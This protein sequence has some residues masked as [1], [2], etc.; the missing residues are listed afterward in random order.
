MQSQS[1]KVRDDDNQVAKRKKDE[2]GNKK[3]FPLLYWLFTL[4]FITC[5]MHHLDA[6]WTPITLDNAEI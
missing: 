2:S 6:R 3:N 5:E 1:S 4:P